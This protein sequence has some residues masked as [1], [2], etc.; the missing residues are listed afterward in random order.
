MYYTITE[1]KIILAL[2]LNQ[3]SYNYFFG[4]GLSKSMYYLS[5]RPD[6]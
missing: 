4:L 2:G 5:V 3:S 1:E 6:H